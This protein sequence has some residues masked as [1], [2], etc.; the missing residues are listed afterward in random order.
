MLYVQK[1]ADRL[2]RAGNWQ[3]VHQTGERMM[4]Q[5]VPAWVHDGGRAVRGDGIHQGDW[6]V[7][8]CGGLRYRTHGAGTV[9]DHAQQGADTLP[10]LSTPRDQ[11][12]K[13][14]AQRLVDAGAAK[15]LDDE[16][17][18]GEERRGIAEAADLK[19]SSTPAAL[20]EDAGGV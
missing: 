10:A 1:H 19:S 20:R 16:N 9:A 13:H 6:L 17:D 3:F 2:P 4:T 18:S 15:V 12:Q 8:G 14:N 11:H 7:L 5:M